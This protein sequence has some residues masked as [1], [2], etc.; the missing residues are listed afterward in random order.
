[1]KCLIWALLDLPRH[2]SGTVGRMPQNRAGSAVANQ[3]I[4]VTNII[5]LLQMSALAHSCLI[6]DPMIGF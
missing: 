6:A 2:L 3:A 5:A 4:K 1:M